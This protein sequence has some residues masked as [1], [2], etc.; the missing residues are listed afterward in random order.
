MALALTGGLY[1]FF[2]T[3]LGWIGVAVTG[4]DTST[5]VLFGNLQKITAQQIGIDPY[6]MCSGGTTGG[7]MGKAIAAQSIVVAS[8]ATNMQ[9]REG[10]IIRRVFPHSFV[11]ACLIGVLVY[12]QA[13][14]PPFSWMVEFI[15]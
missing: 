11:L 9:G 15:R 3:M 13:Y 6:L 12:L 10:D 5:N 1:P 2:G 14:I 4:S 7:V 8:T